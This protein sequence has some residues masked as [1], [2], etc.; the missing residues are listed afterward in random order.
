M[1]TKS[2]SATTLKEFYTRDEAAAI[3]EIEPQGVS[4]HV[5]KGRLNPVMVGRS[6]VYP[7]SEVEALAAEK[8]AGNL[9]PGPKKST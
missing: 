7:K 5:N 4:H 3:L 1:A 6:P 2:K 9:K 8:K